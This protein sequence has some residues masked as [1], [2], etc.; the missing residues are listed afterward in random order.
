MDEHIFF[1][2]IT[3]QAWLVHDKNFLMFNILYH[4]LSFTSITRLA[5][6]TGISSF[7][8]PKTWQL[9]LF[10]VH[11]NNFYVRHFQLF[12]RPEIGLF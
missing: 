4:S 10:S 9:I 7:T 3:F 8:H 5:N 6:D 1:T 12:T 2:S 11:M